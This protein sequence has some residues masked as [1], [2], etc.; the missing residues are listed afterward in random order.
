MLSLQTVEIPQ[1]QTAAT[2]FTNIGTQVQGYSGQV[3]VAASLAWVCDKTGQTCTTT[4]LLPFD[5]LRQGW[6]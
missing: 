4:T 1:A 6:L 2:T 3:R 5:A